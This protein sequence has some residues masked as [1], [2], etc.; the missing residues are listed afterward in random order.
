MTRRDMIKL[1]SVVALSTVT[2]S[3]YDEKLV[4]NETKMTPKD[5]KNMTKG[6]HKHTPEITIGSKDKA[7]YTLVEVSVGQEGIIHPST[8]KH[9]IY[10][11]CLFADGKEIDAVKL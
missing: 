5:P 1:S 6:E 7:G 10:E 4:D 2:A 11:V 8:D 9:W 3:A